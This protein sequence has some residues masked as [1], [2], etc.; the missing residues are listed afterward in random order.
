MTYAHYSNRNNLWAL[1]I[2]SGGS[3]SSIGAHRITDASEIIENF[4]ADPSGEWLAYDSDRAGS[5]DIFKVRTSGGEPIRLTSAA[6]NEFSPNF[7]PDGKQIAFHIPRNGNRDIFTI[8]AD[9]GQEEPVTATPMQEARADWSPDGA[10][11]VFHFLR[12][13]RG[14]GIVRRQ[15]NGKWGT[16]TVRLDRGNQPKWSPDG[17]TILF[18]GGAESARFELMPADS[19]ASRLLYEGGGNTGRPFPGTGAWSGDNQVYLLVTDAPRH[20]QLIKVN[21]ADGRWEPR[22]NF[23][24]SVHAVFARLIRIVRET[25]YFV[26]ES[27]ESDVWVLEAKA[28]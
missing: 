2:P 9:G 19:G 1:P 7:S 5:V 24:A 16:P 23:D 17:R 8:P 10:A 22:V 20:W 15:P 13:R 4:D 28:P 12:A 11:L 3:V 27:R 14:I 26:T 6:T 21:P 18:R 25:L